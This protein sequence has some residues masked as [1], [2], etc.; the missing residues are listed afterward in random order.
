[1]VRIGNLST[2]KSQ[3]VRELHA[4]TRPNET[5]SR[6]G[7]AANVDHGNVCFLSPA[8]PSDQLSSWITA[9]SESVA[10]KLVVHTPNKVDDRS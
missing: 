9:Q 5:W 2:L 7:C 10:S 3:P 6:N 4:V 8:F 1:M